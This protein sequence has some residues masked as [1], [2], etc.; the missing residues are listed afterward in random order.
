MDAA[1]PYDA[2]IL[3]VKHRQLVAEFTLDRLRS[4]GNG[5]PP[6]LI[7]VKGFFPASAYQSAGMDYWQ[8]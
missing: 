7:D 6:V 8:L 3:A 5:R 4:L 1:G 2:V